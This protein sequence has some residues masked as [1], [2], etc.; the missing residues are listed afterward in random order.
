MRGS[1]SLPV[2]TGIPG[3]GPDQ[4]EQSGRSSSVQTQQDPALVRGRHFDVP[5]SHQFGFSDVDEAVAQNVLSQ[6]DFSVSPLETA[7]VDL[8]L[9]E[10]DARVAQLGDPADVHEDTATAD[11]GHEPDHHRVV[12]PTQADDDVVDLADTLTG[13]R[14][15]LAAQESGQMHGDSVA[16]GVDAALSTVTARRTDGPAKRFYPPAGVSHRG[17]TGRFGPDSGSTPQEAACA[18]GQNDRPAR[19]CAPGSPAHGPR[20][21]ARGWLAKSDGRVDRWP[22]RPQSLWVR[23]ARSWFGPSWV[24]FWGTDEVAA[25]AGAGGSGRLWGHGWSSRNT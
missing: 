8:G 22:G 19:H 23:P 20:L 3:G 14:E 7:Q 10:G 17:A 2:L 4:S 13:R 15:Q 24:Q 5:G 11:L 9:R 21:S 25:C 18:S 6:Q 1:K 16:S 12:I